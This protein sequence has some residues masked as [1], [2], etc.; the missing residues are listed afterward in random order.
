MKRI[1]FDGI[2]QPKNVPTLDEA[3]K[4]TFIK[5]GA[6]G[7][8]WNSYIVWSLSMNWF[9]ELR[10]FLTQNNFFLILSGRNKKLFFIIWKC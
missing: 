4:T 8:K 6:P 3:T 1:I 5:E 10:W 9:I 7:Y 2:V